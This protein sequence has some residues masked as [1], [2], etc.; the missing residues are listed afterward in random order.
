MTTAGKHFLE[1]AGKS[2]RKILVKQQLH[3]AQRSADDPGP[4]HR[5]SRLEYPPWSGRENHP[6]LLERSFRR[7]DSR[8]HRTRRCV[9][10]VC[11]PCRYGP[12]GQ[13]RCVPDSSYW[14][15]YSP[16][17]LASSLRLGACGLQRCQPPPYSHPPWG[18]GVSAADPPSQMAS[19]RDAGKVAR[20]RGTPRT[21]GPRHPQPIAPRQGRGERGA[22]LTR[23]EAAAAVPIGRLACPGCSWVEYYQ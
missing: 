4:P 9:F 5:Q 1:Q 19:R 7:Q 3:W 15:G 10:R 6:E 2:G 8:T 12:A 13:W 20:G 23:R 14:E 22:C 21:P 18:G 16:G 17:C 11:R